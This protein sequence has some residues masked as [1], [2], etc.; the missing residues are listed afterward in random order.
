MW[1]ICI[2]I[3]WQMFLYVT[4]AFWCTGWLPCKYFCLY[5]LKF[6]LQNSS[7]IWKR[8]SKMKRGE[9]KIYYVKRKPKML[10]SIFFS[11]GDGEQRDN[12]GFLLSDSTEIPQGS[13]PVP[14]W[15]LIHWSRS[16]MPPQ[17][18]K[19]AVSLGLHV[20]K[21]F[22]SKNKENLSKIN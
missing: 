16:S 12:L 1:C 14:G 17:K 11:A 18:D 3:C 2:A 8:I 19:S 9:L 6:Y 10:S 20:K 22:V 15:Q 4:L 13:V 21:N 7:T 5:L